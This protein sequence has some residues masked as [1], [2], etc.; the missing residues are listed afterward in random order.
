MQISDHS[1]STFSS[2]RSRNCRKPRPCLIWPNTGSTVP[3]RNARCRPRLV[4]NF[5]LIRP[6]G[7]ILGDA[8]SG[9]WRGLWPWRVFSGATNGSHQKARRLV[10]SQHRPSPLHRRSMV[11]CA[12][13]CCL[14][15]VWWARAI[16]VRAVHH[17]LVC[18]QE[19]LPSGCR[20]DARL[21]IGE[22]AL[23][24]VLGHP[25]MLTTFG[26]RSAAT[27]ASASSAAMASRPSRKAN[28]QLIP[29]CL[30]RPPVLT[31]SAAW[32]R[33]ATSAANALPS[34]ASW[35][36]MLRCVGLD[37]RP[38]SATCPTSPAPL[39]QRQLQADPAL[40]DAV[41]DGASGVL[42]AASTRKAMSSWSRWAMRR[43]DDTPTQ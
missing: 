41:A 4:C 32:A 11:S 43:D 37:L 12:A 36:L 2:P 13:A 28:R 9:G 27:C 21:G 20:H 26:A 39:A 14:S 24:L 31:S 10:N 40:P 38:S 17:R 7:Q 42:F 19:V 30:Y 18:L 16:T 5:R 1:P 34:P 29:T 22:V 33:R 6:G 8:S 3:M 23:G 15:V 25:R 35:S